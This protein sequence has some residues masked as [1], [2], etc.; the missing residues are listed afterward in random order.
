MDTQRSFFIGN[1]KNRFV[2]IINRKSHRH[3]SANTN[4]HVDQKGDD[5]QKRNHESIIVPNHLHNEKRHT[6]QQKNIR[7]SLTTAKMFELLWFHHLT[8]KWYRTTARKISH[9]FKEL[10][11]ARRPALSSILPDDIFTV[12][13]NR[14]GRNLKFNHIQRKRTNVARQSNKLVL[15]DCGQVQA[16]FPLPAPCF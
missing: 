1:S 2:P 4:K 3:P 9:V 11:F 13:P 8:Q 10:A 15:E 5:D 6:N 14:P 16:H 12:K 7:K